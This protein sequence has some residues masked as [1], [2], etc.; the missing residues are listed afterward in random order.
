MSW[1]LHISNLCNKLSK[2][3]GIIYQIRKKL[4]R[5]ALLNI[6]YSLC[7]PLITY[8]ITIWGGA[9]DKYVNRVYMLQKHIIRTI[10]FSRKYS[11]MSPIFEQLNILKLHNVYKLF[12][13]TLGYKVV[14]MNYSNN[15]FQVINHDHGTRGAD[16]LMV[17]PNSHNCS[18]I[19]KSVLCNL[20]RTWNE[21]YRLSLT[22]IN[23]VQ[24]KRRVRSQLFEDQSI[25]L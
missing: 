7:Y 22:S 3:N 19:S 8:G 15:V 24:F 5:A 14:L 11:I 2:L 12:L 20:P 21:V 4:T 1:E 16:M 13:C 9:C 10:T 17:I 6:Y 23:I 25:Y 18:L